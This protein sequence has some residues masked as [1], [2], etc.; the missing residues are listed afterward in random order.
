M[1]HNHLSRS[2]L[3]DGAVVFFAYLSLFFIIHVVGIFMGAVAV[4][5]VM[6]MAVMASKNSFATFSYILSPF[7][8]KFLALVLFHGYDLD[9]F[10]FVRGLDFISLFF[11]YLV[12]F[13]KYQL[14]N[15]L[16]FQKID[17]FI[18]LLILYFFY[19]LLLNSFVG[20]AFYLR[21]FMMPMMLISLFSKGVGINEQ[22]VKYVQGA[23]VF[24]WFS[25]VSFLF[26]ELMFSEFYYDIFNVSEYLT[27]KRSYGEYGDIDPM[28]PIPLFNFFN[29]VMLPR[30]RGFSFHPITAAYLLS[31]VTIVVSAGRL[32]FVYFTGLILC[33]LIGSKGALII[34]FLYAFSVLFGRT[35]LGY[36]AGALVLVLLIVG[37][38]F[39]DPHTYSLLTS[40]MKLPLKPFG[41][42]LGYGGSVGGGGLVYDYSSLDMLNGDS[43]LAVVVNMFGF[44]GFYFYFIF[45]KYILNMAGSKCLGVYCSAIGGLINSIFQEEALGFYGLCLV[46]VLIY[47][48]ENRKQVISDV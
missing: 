28:E 5:P 9:T 7:L 3:V 18:F 15:G 43:G 1:T 39:N 35:Y 24:I 13:L 27:V 46:I 2:S 25:I 45:S 17:I 47:F 33:L 40:F 30:L 19:S 12:V 26:F 23:L 44:I 14:P 41:G 36:L 4:V 22:E 38:F 34:M 32:G 20:A 42:G 10:L 29:D 21:Y 31:I 48:S 11:I 16:Q 8:V 6:F 37:Y